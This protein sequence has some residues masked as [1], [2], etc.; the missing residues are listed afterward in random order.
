MLALVDSSIM[1]CRKFEAIS[2]LNKC[3]DRPGLRPVITGNATV[4]T[5]WSPT[6]SIVFDIGRD[7]P[8]IFIGAIA[9]DAV[10]GSCFADGGR[11]G[12]SPTS[13]STSLPVTV[14]LGELVIE[15]TVWGVRGP[16][17]IYAN[18]PP[19]AGEFKEPKNTH[20]GHHRNKEPTNLTARPTPITR[21]QY[22]F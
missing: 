8:R 19:S 15:Q 20:L 21:F 17:H 13:F 12:P 7:R 14:A 2:G 1:G 9:R 16:S 3:Q 10:I 5:V 18:P 22:L 6:P 4:W 11:S